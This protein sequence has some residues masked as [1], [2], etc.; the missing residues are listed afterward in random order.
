MSASRDHH[1][2]RLS[3]AL[4]SAVLIPLLV[5]FLGLAA[6]WQLWQYDLNKREEFLREEFVSGIAKSVAAVEERIADYRSILLGLQGLFHASTEVSS[7]E[8]AAYTENMN[9][10]GKYPALQSLAYSTLIPSAQK[11][12]H[13]AA[14]RS[15]GFLSYHIH[16]DGIRDYYVPV[17]YVAP[18]RDHNL[19]V[20]GLDNYASVERRETLQRARDSGKEALSGK[21]QLVQDDDSSQPGIL[22]FL[23]VYAAGMAHETQRERRTAIR[24][25][26]G[27]A[28]RINP[29]MD[30]VMAQSEHIYQLAIYDGADI[31]PQAQLYQSA[32]EGNPRF[33][34]IQ[35]IR[36]SGR[37]WTLLFTSTPSFEGRLLDPHHY[38]LLITGCSISLVLALII[39][40]SLSSR[41]RAMESAAHLEQANR[42]KSEFIANIT[43]ELR[44]PMNAILG[45]TTLA[46]NE[47]SNPE[48]REQLGN[49]QLS[50]E[51]LLDIIN[52][53]LDFS[54][55]E[56]GVLRIEPIDFSLG[57]AL[58]AVISSATS[59]ATSKQLEL[60]I[61]VDTELYR[62]DLHGDRKR[63]VQVL[64]NYLDNAIKFTPQGGVTLRVLMQNENKDACSLR[65]EIQDSGIGIDEDKLN[66]LYELF[67][68]ADT[69]TNRQYEG[70]GLGLAIN[71]S[72]IEHMPD[73]EYGVNSTPGLGSLFWFCVRMAKSRRPAGETEQ[74]QE[75]NPARLDG[76]RLLL[77]E[78]NP[79]SQSITRSLLESAGAEVLVAGNGIEALN[80]LH[81]KH[82]DAVLMDVQMPK[83]DGLETIRKIRSDPSLAKLPVIA[84]TAHASKENRERCLAAGMND[85]ISKPYSPS[86][87]YTTLASWLSPD[88]PLP[89][90]IPPPSAATPAASSENGS[91]IDFSTLEELIGDDRGKMYDFAC[92]FVDL[93]R[94]DLVRLDEALQG[95]DLETVGKLAHHNKA[96]ARMVGA[97][98]FA[99]L[100]QEL[101]ESCQQAASPSSIRA[102]LEAMSPLLDR[103]EQRIHREL[104]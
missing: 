18:F 53:I 51:H 2:P 82:C 76:A 98:G 71:K 96:P 47:E 37:E 35:H 92:R 24:G 77:A 89:S 43:H 1:N 36:I 85:F 15:Q 23:P 68:Q 83:M 14:M 69:A 49:I 79:L 42:A 84:L 66:H 41:N 90:V 102:T 60:S 21:L 91:V 58:D 93:A 103:I 59:K 29:L 62:Y 45:M 67:W 39:W 25:W 8:F 95:N 80:I 33:R 19:R 101:I 20:L 100:C 10:P 26:V 11:D 17:V 13:I 72:L 74:P 65:F 7:Q 34:N 86:L 9:I 104:A 75:Y 70:L 22:M 28:F 99:A 30:H 94:A 16:P 27:A 97:N 63:L 44:S 52:E 81:R 55:L 32:G 31:T 3:L 40:L 73:G 48:R 5:L 38:L 4:E 61:D 56:S 54:N 12:S 50:G 87:L 6:T 88:L 78:D 57:D 46:L 64:S